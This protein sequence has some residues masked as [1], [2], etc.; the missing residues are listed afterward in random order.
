MPFLYKK[1]VARNSINRYLMCCNI[2]AVLQCL[3]SLLQ[4]AYVVVIF[5]YELHLVIILSFS[6]TTKVNLS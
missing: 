3:H 1:R 5:V 4:F 6:M 2:E